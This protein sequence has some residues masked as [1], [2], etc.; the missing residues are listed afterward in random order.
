MGILNFNTGD[1]NKWNVDN[2]DF[3][4]IKLNELVPDREYPFLGCFV[5]KDSGYGEGAV[6]ITADYNINCPARYV[7]TFRKMQHDK[8]VEAEANS[9]RAYFKYT[10]F[11]SEKY[12]KDGYR[13]EFILK[14]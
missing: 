4:Y 3:S 12:N 10:V 5:S 7:E 2:K 13:L 9:G 6:L 8:E 1:Y 11:R 14:K